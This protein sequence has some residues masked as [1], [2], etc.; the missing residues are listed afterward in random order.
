MGMFIGLVF[1][2]AIWG[3]IMAI[4]D[5]AAMKRRKGLGVKRNG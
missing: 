3:L 4:F 1:A 5:F 2:G